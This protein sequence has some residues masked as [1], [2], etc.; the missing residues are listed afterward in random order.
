MNEKNIK[1][2]QE[3]GISLF[4][5]YLFFGFCSMTL[6]LCMKVTTRNFPHFFSVFKFNIFFVFKNNRK[7]P[8]NE[9]INIIYQVFCYKQ[10]KQALKSTEKIWCP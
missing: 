7:I 6:Y 2:V 8:A 4:L 10:K 5:C 3:K 9:K 1:H